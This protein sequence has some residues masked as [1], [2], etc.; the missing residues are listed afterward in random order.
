MNWIAFFLC[1]FVQAYFSIYL[2][3]KVD[4]VEH[5]IS[6]AKTI[7]QLVAYVSVSAIVGLVL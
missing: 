5:D 1:L 7:M 2:M 4:P 3:S 6:I